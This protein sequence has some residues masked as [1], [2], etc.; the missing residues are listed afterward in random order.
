VAIP[1]HNE[2]KYIE[3]CLR[4]ILQQ[5]VH[6]TKI[7]LV[8]DKCTDRTVEIAT[9]ILPMERSAI[10]RKENV[11]WQYTYSENL[12]LARQQD[13]DKKFRNVFTRRLFEDK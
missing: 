9:S 11:S 1:A 6:P 3:D 13:P 7:I 5:T 4:S 8:A 10:L 2:E 12:E